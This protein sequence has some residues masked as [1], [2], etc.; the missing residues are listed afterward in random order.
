LVGDLGV[1]LAEEVFGLGAEVAGVV[2]VADVVVVGVA[3]EVTGDPLPLGTTAGPVA[4]PGDK[5]P[6]LAA[7]G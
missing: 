4:T 1:G 3:P 2:G 6:G 7:G 5:A